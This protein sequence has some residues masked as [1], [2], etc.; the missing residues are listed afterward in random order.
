MSRRSMGDDQEVYRVVVRRKVKERNPDWEPG[1]PWTILADG[2]YDTVYGPYATIGAARNVESHEAYKPGC[3]AKSGK[4]RAE[5]QWDVV[6]SWIERVVE[7]KW[8]KA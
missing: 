1:Q 7:I 3:V 4:P 6:D 8:E 2:E 5:F